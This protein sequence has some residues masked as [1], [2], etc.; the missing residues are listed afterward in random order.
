MKD[1]LLNNIVM[2]AIVLILSILIVLILPGCYSEKL[3][4]RQ[5]GKAGV[6]YP[7]ILAKKAR[8]IFPCVVKDSIQTISTSDS[9]L[10]KDVVE[11][12]QGDLFTSNQLADSLIQAL[13]EGDTTCRKYSAVIIELQRQIMALKQ[14]VITIPPVTTITRIVEKVEDKA[15]LYACES[16]KSKA[17][18]LA[19][20]F[21]TKY[22][23][24]DK[25]AKKRFWIIIGLS[26]AMALGIYASI[27]K[28]IIKPI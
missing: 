27:R 5:V 21:K 20:D 10:Y 2:G 13:S 18:D 22:E 12:L 14:K 3:A 11:E 8:D 1:R 25:K 9:A 19:T 7:A 17:I 23:A 28:K 24:A 15:A 16:D 6:Y 4:N 26:A